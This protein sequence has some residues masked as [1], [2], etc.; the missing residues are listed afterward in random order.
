MLVCSSGREHVQHRRSAFPHAEA[1]VAP[2]RQG[3]SSCRALTP[4]PP[5]K[6]PAVRL[7]TRAHAG[8]AEALGNIAKL[9]FPASAFAGVI[10]S[11]EVSAAPA[12]AGPLP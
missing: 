7:R 4:A 12:P 9:G 3:P 1:G 6:S 2:R 10:S 8:S 11:G 5:L